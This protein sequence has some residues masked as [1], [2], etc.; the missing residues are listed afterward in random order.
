MQSVVHAA[1]GLPHGGPKGWWVV[2][3]EAQNLKDT[4]PLDTYLKSLDSP[5]AQPTAVLILCHMN[6]T[7]DR[8]KPTAKLLEKVGVLFESAKLREWQLSKMGH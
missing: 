3:R 4:A 8:R 6:G 7:L 2:V 1:S 5:N